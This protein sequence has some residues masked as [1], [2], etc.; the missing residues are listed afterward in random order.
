MVWEKPLYLADYG[1]QLGDAR[2]ESG[3]LVLGVGALVWVIDLINAEARL[4]ND[5]EST[6]ETHN[7][8]A[9]QAQL[10]ATS[11]GRPFTVTLSICELRNP[12]AIQRDFQWLTIRFEV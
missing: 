8:L 5:S 6:C 10:S 1:F 11:T 4:F 12:N 3:C 2:Y 9:H 7:D